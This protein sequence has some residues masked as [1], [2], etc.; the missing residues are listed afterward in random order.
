MPRNDILPGGTDDCWITINMNFPERTG[1]STLGCQPPSESI[2]Q[3]VQDVYGWRLALVF[4]NHA[5]GGQCPYY[6]ASKC[7]HCDIGAGDGI[8]FDSS[9]NRRRLEWFCEYYTDVLPNV[10]HMVFYNSGSVFSRT[11]MPAELLDELTDFARSLPAI[12]V[13]SLDS[14]EA[15]ISEAAVARVANRFGS[16]GIVRPILGLETADDRLRNEVLE[17]KM[18]R[19]AVL[20]AFEAV[21]S[22]ARQIGVGRVGMDV[23]VL[24]GGPGTDRAT[25]V[26]DAVETARFALQSGQQVGISVDLNIHPYYPSQRGLLKFPQHPRCPHEVVVAAISEIVNLKNSLNSDGTI[27]VGWQDEGHDKQPERRATELDRTV[28][29]LELFNRTQDSTVLTR[30]SKL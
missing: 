28:T 30:H 9:L 2:F 18:P 15:F 22:V 26:G 12:K 14:R 1:N 19:T 3:P 13:L 16:G 25:A 10:N 29:A 6:V 24:V 7:H 11:E 17:K 5:P 20:R 4:G 8:E 23:N 27:F 21:G